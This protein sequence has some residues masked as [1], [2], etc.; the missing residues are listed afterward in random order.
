MLFF[1]RV[2]Y[3]KYNSLVNL[4]HLSQ[5]PGVHSGHYTA[6]MK[7]GDDW[8]YMNDQVVTR[9][10]NAKAWKSSENYIMFYKM[11]C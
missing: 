10:D 4:C 1:T 3:Y 8:W 11:N 6:M 7:K 5:G 2:C 9:R